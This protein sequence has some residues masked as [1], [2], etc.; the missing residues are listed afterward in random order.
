VK[1]RGASKVPRIFVT[2]EAGEVQ[3][4]AGPLGLWALAGDLAGAM[5]KHTEMA[6]GGTVYLK[7]FTILS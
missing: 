1:A 5:D 7:G 2:T 6:E 3:Q 4:F